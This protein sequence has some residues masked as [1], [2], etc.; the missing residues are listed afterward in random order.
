MPFCVVKVEMLAVEEIFGLSESRAFGS[1]RDQHPV[2]RGQHLN[3]VEKSPIG[4]VHA[5]RMAIT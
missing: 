1:R 3:G 2:D 4:G 5:S